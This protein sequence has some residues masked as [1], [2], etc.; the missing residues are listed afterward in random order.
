MK[1]YKVSKGLFFK[2]DFM[3]MPKDA[4]IYIEKG[5]ILLPDKVKKC[6]NRK[7][8]VSARAKARA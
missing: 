5:K 2:E 3:K 4:Y 7:K 8:K 1:T 6:V